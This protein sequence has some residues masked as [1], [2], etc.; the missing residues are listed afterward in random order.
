RE[1]EQVHRVEQVTHRDSFPGSASALLAVSRPR[2]AARARNGKQ[3]PGS[4][5]SPYPRLLAHVAILV[6]LA[7]AARAPVVA[8]AA[9]AVVADRLRLLVAL[10]AVGDGRL[11]LAA[12]AP[13]VRRRQRPR[14]RLVDRRPDRPQRLLEALRLLHAEHRLGHLVL[15]P[16]P[17]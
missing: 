17:H 8:A 10:L 3:E 13:L 14:R 15:H 2:D 5:L 1:D 9:L 7:A 6:F 12:H 16:L 4:P 11:L